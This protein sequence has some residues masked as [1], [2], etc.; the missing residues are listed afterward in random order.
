MDTSTVISVGGSTGGFTQVALAANPPTGLKAAINFAGGSG[1]D[2]KGNLCDEAGLVG[3]YKS[4]GKHARAPM[5]WIYS[6]NDKWFPPSFARKFL[7]AFEK[8]GGD[9][10]FV[11]ARPD[12]EDGHGLYN[13]VP[14]WSL[15]VQDFLQLH[16]LLPVN[17][18]YP[19]PLPPRVDPPAGLS[20]REVEAFNTFLILGPFKAFATN[21]K[22]ISWYT[23]GQF[24]Q[25]LADQHALENCNKAVHGGP[26]CSIVARTPPQK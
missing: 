12:G 6:E 16:D 9:A 13:H 7:A 17:P 21:G 14:V 19:G 8:S 3:A 2:G 25:A 22:G 11:V 5:L 23:V 18:P 1:G 20:P 15:T 10:E 4:F 26:R 24:T